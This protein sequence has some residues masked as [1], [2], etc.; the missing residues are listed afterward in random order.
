M[1]GIDSRS[2]L[3]VAQRTCQMR[4][5]SISVVTGFNYGGTSRARPDRL[6]PDSTPAARPWARRFRPMKIRPLQDRI[7][8]KRIEEEETSKGGIIIPDTA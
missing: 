8:V 1:P 5:A 6:H 4:V 7:L 3:A 2:V